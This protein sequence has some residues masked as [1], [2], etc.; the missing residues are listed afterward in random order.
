MQLNKPLA[1]C[2]TITIIIFAFFISENVKTQHPCPTGQ[3]ETLI[4]AHPG[5]PTQQ[6][7]VLIEYCYYQ[8][9]NSGF[10]VITFGEITPEP[11]NSDHCSWFHAY[12]QLFFPK[13]LAQIFGQILHI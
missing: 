2:L 5:D 11:P 10:P 6:C 7:S 12:V 9:P 1:L 13:N 3:F 4:I 8:D